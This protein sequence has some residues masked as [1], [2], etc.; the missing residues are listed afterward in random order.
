MFRPRASRWLLSSLGFALLLF[1]ANNIHAQTETWEPA[2]TRFTTEIK[3]WTSSGST[4]AKVRLTFST[5]GYR[6]DWGQIVRTGNNFVADA[7]VERWT[8]MTTQA[9]T[10]KENTYNLGALSPGSYTFTFKSYGVAQ[11]SQQFDPSL[12]AER[13]EPA[14]L[15]GDRVGIRIATSTGGLIS[16]R[17]ELYF[18]DTG[19]RVVDWGQIVRS[20][21]ELS[22]DVKVEQW[23]GDSE[24]RVTIVAH[25]YGPLTLTPGAYSLI[26]KMYG[27]TVKTQP[28]S[29]SEPSTPAPNLLTEENS[30][31]AVALD[32]VTWLR[33]FPL[34]TIYNFSQD[35]R[36]RV[37]LFLSGVAWAAS[38]TPPAVTAQAEDAGHVI[39]PLPVEYVGKV[40]NFDWLTQV[41]I[42]LPEG[43]KEGTD[44]WVS[45]NVRG[46]P[47]NKGL[48]SIKPSGANTQ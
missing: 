44:V 39:Y 12:I 41:I 27:A 7:R 3:V 35:R 21:N 36:T 8:G 28:F 6:V 23:T 37:V 18:P 17:V 24:A 2:T 32:S 30:E 42:T 19:Y 48:V 25:D 20:G 29:V 45:V 13:W 38:E 4:Y 46:V 5:G 9:I 33:L 26:V 11:K 40:P 10:F 43:L 15:P 31:R 1:S 16:P 47:S 34:V 22:V 14:Q